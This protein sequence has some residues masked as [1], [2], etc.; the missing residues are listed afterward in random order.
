MYF[1]IEGNLPVNDVRVWYP[2]LVDV[3]TL[4]QSISGRVYMVNTGLNPL[5]S[6]EYTC[7]IGDQS[8]NGVANTADGTLVPGSIGAH[9]YGA[10][11]TN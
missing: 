6:V 11:I 10:I 5:Q 8:V 1:G 3:V 4:G 2:E 9:N 7:T